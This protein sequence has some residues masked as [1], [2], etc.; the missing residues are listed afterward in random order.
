[1]AKFKMSRAAKTAMAS[2][3]PWNRQPGETPQA[4]EAWEAYQKRGTL[5]GAAEETDKSMAQMSIWSKKWEWVARVRAK[6]NYEL[7]VEQVARDKVRSKQAAI[8]EK[9]KLEECESLY[10]L[11][12]K[13]RNR[14]NTMMDFPLATTKTSQ[15]G[16]EVHVH[17][18]KWTLATAATMARVSAEMIALATDAALDEADDFDPLNATAEECRAYI[19]K[20][21]DRR[22]QIRAITGGGE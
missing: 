5:E 12:L 8:W 22:K 1:M 19:Q 20:Q 17:P 9:R 21:V 6:E 10:S 16:K 15:D 3:H 13:L 7:N 2:V 11:G 4:W 14:A 18:S